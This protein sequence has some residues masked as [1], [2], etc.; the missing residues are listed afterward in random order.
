MEE[1]EMEPEV[2][3]TP[4]EQAGGPQLSDEEIAM[5]EQQMREIRMEDVLT[6]T[7]VS[8]INL[9]ARR[10]AKEDEVDLEQARLGI[11]AVRSLLPLLPEEVS[12]EIREPLS[13]IQLLYAQK[14]GEGDPGGQPGTDA[15]DSGPGSG[16][17]DGPAAGSGESGLWTPRGS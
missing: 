5:L 8:L 16:P 1:N 12:K 15:P 7:V 2:D 13:Q 17:G 4:T 6:Q 9:T 11:E 10:I 3:P 14:S